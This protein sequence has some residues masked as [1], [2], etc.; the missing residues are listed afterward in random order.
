MKKKVISCKYFT[1]GVLSVA[2]LVLV[3]CAGSQKVTE[4]APSSPDR[5]AALDH[6]MNGAILDQKE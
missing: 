2:I 3:G 4:P 1:S 6:F 5:D